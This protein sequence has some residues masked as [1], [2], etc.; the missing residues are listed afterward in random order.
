[1]KKI[2][3]LVFGVVGFLVIAAPIY[4]ESAAHQV[5]ING[6]PFAKAQFINNQWVIAIDDFA[7]AAGG[8]LTLEP[9]F[10]LQGNRLIGLLVPA[11]NA[12]D[13]HKVDSAAVLGGS[14]PAVQQKAQGAIIL[15]DRVFHVRKAGE[16]S[17]S[18]FLFNGKAYVPLADVV[19]A[20]GGG[21]FNAAGNLKP[22]ESLSLNFTF[23]G[24]GVLAFHQ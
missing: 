5:L 6:K 9:N 21:V 23:N 15:Q 2:F 1:M 13:K 17:R 10:Q 19:K 8:S 4:V 12:A 22:G 24:D 3:T 18:V 11:V 14:S 20:F 16:I 7:K